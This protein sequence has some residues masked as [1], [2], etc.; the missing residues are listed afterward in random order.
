MVG[1]E[2]AA[3]VAIATC[4]EHPEVFSCT[5]FFGPQRCGKTGVWL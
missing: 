2:R 3:L 5:P 1:L 4:G